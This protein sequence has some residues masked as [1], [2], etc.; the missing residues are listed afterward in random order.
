[1][2]RVKTVVVSL[3]MGIVACLVPSTLQALEYQP[4]EVCRLV[5]TRLIGLG[6]PL[7]ANTE[8]H[9]DARGV[10]AP[11]QGGTAGCMAPTEAETVVVN[12]VAV[13]ASGTGFLEVYPWQ[14]RPDPPTSRLNYVVT[15][16]IANEIHLEL[17]PISLAGFEFSVRPSTSTH[18]I[19]DLI[20]YFYTE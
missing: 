14:A 20:G 11:L 16:A 18:V 3:V 8:T 1:M 10:S 17:A 6:N 19:V 9:F 5:D 4:L 13:G 12:V 15:T 7:P 2:S